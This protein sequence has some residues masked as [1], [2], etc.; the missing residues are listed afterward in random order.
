MVTPLL[1][2]AWHTGTQLPLEPDP[3]AASV[4]LFGVGVIDFAVNIGTVERISDN[5][6]WAFGTVIAMAAIGALLAWIKGRRFG[7]AER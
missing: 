6:S 2:V 1:Y 4:K 7:S 3:L 5:L